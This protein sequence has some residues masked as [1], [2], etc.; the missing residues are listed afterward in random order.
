MW[1]CELAK[2]DL[3]HNP[4]SARVWIGL[5]QCEADFCSPSLLA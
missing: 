1:L 5:A 4:R 3:R 2:C